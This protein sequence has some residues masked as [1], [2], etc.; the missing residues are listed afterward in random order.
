MALQEKKYAIDDLK[1]HKQKLIEQLNV[2]DR[3]LVREQTSHFEQR[4]FQLEDLV[5]RKIQ[6]SV[7]NLEKLNVVQSRFQ[8]LMEWAAEQQPNIVEALKQSP[9]PGMAQHLLMDHL[10]IC[11]QLEAKQVLLKSLMKDADCVM[12]DL[13]LNERKMI[14]KALSE[15]QKH[16]SCLSDL[17]DQRRKYLNKALSEKTQFLMAVFQATSQIQQHERKIM[18]R[19][20]ICLLPDDVSKQVKTCKT[21]QASL[22]TYQN[23]VT[24]LW[25]QGR[26]LMKGITE[27]ERDEVLGKLQELQT[28]YDTVLQKCSHRLQELEK[29]LVSRKHFKE[30]FDKAC[31]WLKQVDIV[32]FPEINL[33][34]ERVELHTQLDKYQSIL[35][36]SPEYENLL[37]TLQTTG[38]AM[39]PSLNE[40]DHSYLSE[41]LNALPQQFNVIVALAKDKF[42]K[43]QEAILDRKEYAS[44]IELT[45]QSL[46]DLEDQFLKMRKMPSDLIVEESVLLQES[47]RTLLGE[48][49]ALGEAVNELNQKKESFRSTGQPWQPEKM[50]Q[51]AT[52][53]HRLKRQAEQRISLLEDTTN[54]YKEHA[55]MCRQLESQ[56]EVVKREQAKVNEETLPAEE[57][58]KVYH[59][60]AGSLQDSGILLKRVTAHLEDLS[61]HLDP[62]AYEKAKGQVQ[63]WQEE[64]KQMTSDVGE[65]VTECESRMV[66]SIDFQTEMSRSLDWLRRVKAE[67]SGPVCL[68]LS[69]QDI[70]EEIRKIQ[71]HQEE[72][73][74]SLRIM[75]ALS[76]KEQE[77]FT[78]AK[79]LISADLEHTLA[80][81]RELDGDVQE[82]LHTRQ[83]CR[84]RS[85]F[86]FQAA[87][88]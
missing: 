69:L 79:E 76:H 3:E 73:L 67:L 39:L 19:E 78:K 49:V 56:L 1:D 52:M 60:L 6:V 31:H 27:Q 7:T 51:L 26:E 64:L 29:S 45:T 83:V 34:N 38:Q 15:A 22:K 86:L 59:S 32:T 11:S 16:V 74:S 84:G 53:Y 28:V 72:I 62:M 87:Y 42:Y 68:D 23:E 61:P 10:A 5:K 48:V 44:L 12:A 88:L 47:C 57:K 24:G 63:S 14:Q 36:Q 80:E 75:S 71:I 9:P 66:Q 37:L 77:K 55:Q 46:G 43:I 8:E 35:E 50:L 20:Y 85:I 40:V 58:L 82:A 4:W 21:A 25:A 70:Q 33:M 2:D 30:D 41:K 17:V 13:G 81:L 54:A 18:F 65:M